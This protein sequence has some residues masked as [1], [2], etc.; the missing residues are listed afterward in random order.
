MHFIHFYI[1]LLNTVYVL[2]KI[3]CVRIVC[4]IRYIKLLNISLCLNK[5]RLAR[6]HYVDRHFIL[7]SLPNNVW[8]L[9]VFA[10][11]LIKSPKQ[12]LETYCFC[13][14]S[15]SSSSSS[16]SSTSSSSTSS[17]SSSSYYYYYYYSLSFFLSFFLSVDHELVHG[18]SQE[19]L[20]TIS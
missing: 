15:S 19:L 16:P 1:H 5:M 4:D 20:E 7:L 10:P 12:R 6:I 2:F 14:V 18:R 13:S 8:K 17:S 3:N 11:F 9:T